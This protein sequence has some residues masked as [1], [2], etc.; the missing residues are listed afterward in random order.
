MRSDRDKRTD[1][2]REIDDFLSRFDTPADELSADINSY[3]DEQNDT[4]A[5]PAQTFSWK[6]VDSPESKKVNG[7]NDSVVP[8]T[9]DTVADEKPAKASM[10]KADDQELQKTKV[11][12]KNEIDADQDEIDTEAAE[13]AVSEDSSVSDDEA[14]T[15][16]VNTTKK[17]KGK[18]KSEKKGSLG[19]FLF[20]KKNKDYDP[21]QG[22]RYEKD[23]KIIKNKEYKFS[24]LKLLRD[25]VALGAICVLAGIIFVYA[26]VSDAPKYDYKDVYSVIDTASI[27]YDDQGKQIDN[28]FYTENRKVVKY[29]DMPEDLIN[30]FIAIEDKTFWKHHGFNWTRMIGA[31]LSSLTGSGRI[32]GTSTITQQL[33]RNVYLADIKS[34]RSI[35]RKL[36]EMYYA[37]RLEHALT[38][39]EII[40]AYL[41]TIYLGHGCYGV[42]A[43]ARTYFSKSVKKLDLVECAALAALPQSPDT[44]ALL[45]LASEA[46]DVV[47]SKVVASEPD[48]VVTNDL[49]R[50]RRQLCLD[51]MLSQGLIDKSEYDKAYDLTLNEFIDPNLKSNNSIYSY[52]HEYLVDT[53]IADLM[54]QYGMEYDE[55][56]RT[57][58]TKGLQIY[59]TVDSKA[60]KVIAKEFQD[61]SN[62]PYVSAAQDADGNLLNND[63][64]IALYNYHNFFD[65]DGDF[66]LSGSAGDVKV[67]KDGSIT[68]MKNH[69][70]HIYET[71]VDGATDYSI[72]FKNYYYYGDNGILYSIAGGYLNIPAAYKTADSD[73]NIVIDKAFF[74]DEYYK[75]ALKID[76]K[77]VILTQKSYTLSPKQRQPQA[78]MT[79]VGVGTGEVKAM[80]G[81]RQFGG[82]KV[83][84]RSLNPRQPGSSI[85]PLAVYGAALQKSYELASDGKKWKFTNFHIDNQGT[86]GW[87][88][89][90]TV[91]SSIEDERTKIEGK[92]WPNNFNNSFSGQNTFKTA[93]QK[94]INTCAVKLILQVGS[95]YSIKQLKKFGLTTVQ[96]DL[97]DPVN[98]ANPAALGLGAM[99]QG[100][101]P[102]E[103]A[104]AYAAFPGRGKINTPICYTKVLDRNGEVLLEGKSEQSRALNKG[105]AWIMQEVLKSVVDYNGYMYVTEIEPGGKT[106]TTNDQYDIWFD[107]FTQAY[108]ASIWIGTDENVEMSSMSTPAAALWG[109]IMDQIPGARKGSYPKKPSNV[110]QIGNEYFTKGTETG[111][112][113]WS[114][115]AE[116]KKQRERAYKAWQKEREKHKKKVPAQYEEVDDKSNP[117]YDT[118]ETQVP[119]YGDKPIVGYEQKKVTTKDPETGEEITEYVDDESKPIY[120]EAEIIGYETKTE[121][122]IIGYKKKKVLVKKETWEYEKGW[123]DGDFKYKG[124]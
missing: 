115:K 69:K 50:E 78:A 64:Q 21:S 80:V 84:N 106:G 4:K 72:E 112:T 45:K 67:G 34:V 8:E 82:Q 94:S 119:I 110:V 32:S 14:E 102:L 92:Y 114:K 63:G 77:N 57:V 20:L 121:K 85:K 23:G 61:G 75:G 66:K 56:E 48:T 62:F 113:S 42:N 105:V 91:H 6:I 30:S 49:S 58:Y 117:I 51:L 41:N 25:L 74:E 24:F 76:G 81:G 116:E 123:R 65:K 79:I 26:L 88:D 96:D 101:E 99:T 68:I 120:G 55:A 95:E 33:A 46:Q 108:A 31:V 29:E 122:V 90:V 83:L 9:P 3:L 39:E 87:G 71:E 15:A 60:M 38:K 52:F 35:K 104:L 17:K 70:L 16:A 124:N 111:L 22:A 98:D 103:M 1:S 12:D 44:Y 28:I 86:K 43:A 89:Y 5:V 59:S 53:I 100:V 37:S 11:I 93:I 10:E 118:K 27:V 36:L 2:E 19:Q 18:K 7:S 13:A 54:E 109:K 47:D 97:S 40:E 107:G 73:G